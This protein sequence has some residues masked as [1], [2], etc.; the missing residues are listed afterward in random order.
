LVLEPERPRTQARGLQPVL[1]PVS[2]SHRTDRDD[3]GAAQR[4]TRATARV[5]R[6]LPVATAFAMDYFRPQP[7][8]E[9]QFDTDRLSAATRLKRSLHPSSFIEARAS[10][11]SFSLRKGTR[12]QLADATA[13]FRTVATISS[14]DAPGPKT[15]DTP[16]SRRRALSEGLITEPP[17][18]S[19]MRS[20]PRSRARRRSSR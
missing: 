14:L 18:I 2:L 9:L 6:L 7:P 1:Q 15:A 13:S 20:P 4:R 16:F 17:I 8:R 11:S 19:G 12:L 3:T 10:C 5:L